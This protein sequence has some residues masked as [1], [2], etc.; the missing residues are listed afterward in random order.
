MN[1]KMFSESDV[2][3]HKILSERISQ[4]SGSFSELKDE[5]RTTQKSHGNSL[6]NIRD[7]LQSMVKLEERSVQIQES[8]KEMRA[9]QQDA[10]F[11]VHDRIDSSMKDMVDQGVSYTEHIIDLLKSM[12][13]IQTTTKTN[14]TK[15]EHV[16]W[17]QRIVTGAIIVALVGAMFSRFYT[18]DDR[19]VKE[20]AVVSNK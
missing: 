4:L 5:L 15:I 8:M 17:L 6:D 19:P 13:K 1:D 10:V 20:V 18:D 11:R 12:G 14:E 16:Q 3:E 9:E 7:S 2:T